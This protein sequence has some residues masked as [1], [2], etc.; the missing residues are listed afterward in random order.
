MFEIALI[1][2][3]SLVSALLQKVLI[4]VQSFPISLGLTAFL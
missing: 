1:R 3:L 4:N 2:T